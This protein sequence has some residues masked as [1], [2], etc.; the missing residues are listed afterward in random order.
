MDYVAD[1]EKILQ[2]DLFWSMC[3]LFEKVQQIKEIPFGR[4]EIFGFAHYILIVLGFK[5]LIHS[6][7]IED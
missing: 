2:S 6:N 4:F 1:V 5:K 7:G 3:M